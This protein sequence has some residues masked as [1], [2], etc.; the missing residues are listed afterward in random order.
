MKPLVCSAI[1]SCATAA[2]AQNFSLTLVPSVQTIDTSAGAVTMTMSVFGD[3][4]VGT[5]MWGGSFGIESDSS[6]VT[7]MSWTPASWSV[8]NI[9]GGYLGNG[10]YN[11]VV[12]GQLITGPNQA[13]WPGS[14]NGMLIGSFEVLLSGFGSVDFELQAGSEDTLVIV[15]Q[16]TGEFFYDTF[17]SLSLGSTQVLLVPS[18]SVGSVLAVAGLVVIR[19]RR[20]TTY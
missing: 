6:N 12:F 15:D 19:R 3:A 20:S 8:Y 9:D 16:F 2:A 5:H 4:D 1:A 14:E 10:N 13:P 11:E 17:G 7:D 18:S